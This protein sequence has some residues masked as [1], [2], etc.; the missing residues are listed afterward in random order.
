M[1]TASPSIEDLFSFEDIYLN[2]RSDSDTRQRAL[3]L[4]NSQGNDPISPNDS[5]EDPENWEAHQK[6]IQ[7]RV[8]LSLGSWYCLVSMIFQFSCN[9]EWT[10]EFYIALAISPFVLLLYFSLWKF[11]LK[12]NLRIL[13]TLVTILKIS[14][15]A[16]CLLSINFYIKLMNDER[17]ILSGILGRIWCSMMICFSLYMIYSCISSIR[18]I[19][20][21]YILS[22]D[23]TLLRMT[24]NTID[25]FCDMI[26]RK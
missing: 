12:L 26:F 8:Y 18:G 19:R 3:P 2:S 9:Y 25:L 1:T 13:M 23:R 21:L 24:E 17:S 16:L 20:E 10:I 4:E 15:I 6:Q 22:T 11:S 7:S 5:E 14:L